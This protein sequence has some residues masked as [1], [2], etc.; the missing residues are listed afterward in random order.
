[1]FLLSSWKALGLLSPLQRIKSLDM[2]S[3]TPDGSQG[4]LSERS[5]ISYRVHHPPPFSKHSHGVLGCGVFISEH[6][7]CLLKA[8]ASFKEQPSETE[9]RVRKT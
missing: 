5:V 9:W 2:G 6:L 8:D 1:M 3:V 4:W 7:S